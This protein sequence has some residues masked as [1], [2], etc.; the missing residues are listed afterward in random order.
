[1][2]HRGSLAW[3]AL[4]VLIVALT[5][6]GSLVGALMLFASSARAQTCDQTGSVITGNWVIT[7]AQVCSDIVYTV[8]GTISVNAGGSLTLINGGLKFTQDTTH[9][10]SLTVNAG[11]TL[12]LDDSVVTTEPRSIDA[13]VKLAFS[14]SSGTFQMRNGAMLKFPGTF[15]SSAGATIDIRSSTITGHDRSVVEP[16]VGATAWD[17]NDDAPTI[18]WASS[19]VD[20]FDSSI[21]KLFEDLSAAAPSPRM[22]LTL[23]GTTTLTAINS[24]IGV[25]FNPDTARLHNEIRALDTSRA[26]LVGVTIDQVQSDAVT[27]DTW[28]P[29]YVP[30]AGGEGTFFLYR[31]LDAFVTDNSGVPVNGAGVWSQM[32]PFIQT[33]YYPDNS[34]LLCPG[35][36]ILGYLGKACGTFNVTGADGRAMIPLFT[37]QINT[38]T[39][40]NAESFGNFEVT[41]LLA[42]N[43]ATG[44]V[45]YD[46]YPIITSASNT[47]SVILA[48]TG[49]TLPRPD[50]WASAAT[51]TPATP[52]AG[53]NVIVQVTVN[54][55]GP[56]GAGTFRVRFTEGITFLAEQTAGPL[57]SGTSTV[58]T[59]NWNNVPAGS[60]TIRV[61]VDVTNVVPETNEANNRA[62]FSIS[63][64]PIGPDLTVG[65]SFSPSPGFAENTV[66]VQATVSNNG[67]ANAS[68]FLVWFKL[69]TLASDPYASIEVPFV[70]TSTIVSIDWV[71]STPGQYTWCAVV[72]PDN[73]ILEPLPYHEDDNSAC[74]NLNVVP[75]PNL[76]IFDQ[77]LQTSDPYPFSGDSVTL[78]ATVRNTGQ[79]PTTVGSAVDFYM[80]DV[81][82]QRVAVPALPVGASA[83][84]ATTLTWTAS[85]CGFRTLKAVVDPANAIQEGS[86]YE[87]DNTVT[88][89]VQ[90]FPPG[91]T[92]WSFTRTLTGVIVP[93]ASS[94]D[95]TG[96]VT[97]VDGGIFISQQSELCN[98]ALIKI[99]GNGRL[100]LVNS[101]IQSNWPL[102]IYLANGGRLVA[103]GGSGLW[104]DAP[105]GPGVLHSDGAAAIDVTDTIV[106][107]D[108]IA[109][110]ASS[111]FKGTTFSG[112]TL[113]I[114]TAGE[115]NLWDASFSGLSSLQ[116]RSD[117][118]NTATPDFDI[119]NTTFDASLT[120]QLRFGGQQWAQLTSVTTTL[121]PG[122]DW[123]TGMITQNA[124]VTRYW[125]LRVEAVDGTGTPLE[126]ANAQITVRRFDP[127][128]ATFANLPAPAADDLYGAS[129]LAWPATAPFGYVIFRASA[130]D[131]FAPG[132]SQWTNAT[133]QASG[134]AVI[135]A[136][137]YYPDQNISAFIQ[138]D[139]TIQLVFSALTPELS[140]SGIKFFHET[141]QTLFPPLNRPINITVDVLNTGAISVRDVTVSFF[142]T[143]VDVNGDGL[144]DNSKA[145]YMASGVWIGDYT[146]PLLPLRSTLTAWIIWTPQGVAEGSR[147]ISVVVD[148]PLTN[149]LDPGKFLEL[150]DRNNIDSVTVTLIVWPDLRV[151]S[152]DIV[153]GNAID[154]NPTTVTVTVHNDGTNDAKNARLF[155]YDNFTWTMAAPL[156]FDVAEGQSVTLS[157]VWTPTAP[158]DHS[159]SAVVSSDPTAPGADDRNVDYN[160]AN[161]GATRTGIT[162]RT[163]PD[164]ELLSADYPGTL[165]AVRGIPF[166]LNVTVYNRGDTDATAFSVSVF[167]DGNTTI[168]VAR[169]DSVTVRANSNARLAV[170]VSANA[171]G[172]HQLSIFADSH[173]ALGEITGFGTI[174]EGSEANNWANQS[175]NLQPP[176]GE[177]RLNPLPASVEP[178]KILKVEGYVVRTGG[179][180]EGIVGLPVTVAIQDSGGA[181]VVTSTQDSQSGGYFAANLAIPA[182]QPNGVYTIRVNTTG[183]SI[184]DLTVSIAIQKPVGFLDQ[185]FLGLPVWVWLIIVIVAVSIVIAVTVYFRVYGLGKMVECGECG[186]FIPEDSTTCPKCGVEFEKDMAKCSN[187][188]AWIP[189]DV[190][191]C[192]EC[193]VEFA[194]GKV[195]MADYQEKMRMQYDEVVAKFREEAQRTLGRALTEREFQDWWRKQ[196]TFVTFED[197]LREEEEM[198]KMGSKPCPV[199]GTL[200]SVTATVCHKCGTYLKEETRPPSGGPPPRGAA[201]GEQAPAEEAGVPPSE[202]IPKKVIRKPV[203]APP[204]VQKKV[205]KKPVGEPPQEGEGESQQPPPEEEF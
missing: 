20:L 149:P 159:L 97:I 93:S 96:D 85:G 75:A 69:G 80:D 144:M 82:V 1:M 18:T 154:D 44:T 65:V 112:T 101:T 48:L 135:S 194:T 67:G 175:V 195:E 90:V 157:V 8:D 205:I 164:L 163:K 72:D 100:T 63:V 178:G 30:V 184:Q 68:N 3:K 50:L 53:S 40:P 27:R 139:T 11:G 179:Q 189:V 181:P 104:L 81:L 130:E 24:Y 21:T 37:D 197:W 92:T 190:K 171:V 200:N 177:F 151:G 74:A 160:L 7:T 23:S 71:P 4:S 46:P 39:A 121:P 132:A 143:L 180:Q 10:Y 148:A 84:I 147:P 113:Y 28:I 150:N 41:A 94:I 169:N 70:S 55:T 2:A 142:A 29:A 111:S 122:T 166:Q 123:W 198:R 173:N 31:W 118:G 62:F 6:M 146:I 59:L 137:T 64:T 168:L 95:I 43:S 91:V 110:G 60:R 49:L 99:T 158:G 19:T 108:V 5:A 120:T 174:F 45:Y 193:G 167:L 109:A 73:R 131:R 119:R 182:N 98:R 152:A 192:P 162:V 145:A 141:N 106:D 47:K 202:P 138:A 153:V 155:M 36:R 191:Q 17:D 125:W 25:D 107:A 16:W 56:G 117:D 79:A 172:L 58:L 35:T 133:Y 126:G 26:F 204:V 156:V 12:I 66:K 87:S 13:Y 14:V 105:A 34:N 183:A 78:N 140:V 57:A 51:F 136:I 165:L 185:I 161:N 15:S 115:S 129:A 196:P 52:L 22:I 86:I 42:P 32:S 9:I 102:T 203:A 61:D 199:C 201:P 103:R 54:N 188:Q 170:S 186:S 89:S 33:A 187:C 77:D 88:T 176:A 127:V 128:T 76:R 114:N 116:L 38:T 83:R 134:S 124:K